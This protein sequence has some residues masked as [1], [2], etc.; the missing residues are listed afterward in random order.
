MKLAR[1]TWLVFQRQMQLVMRN[2]VWVIIGVVQPLYFLFL[3]GPLLRPALGVSTNAEAYRIFI[4]GLL[5]MLA[6]FG[7]MFVGFGLIAELRAGVIERSRVTPVSRLALMVGRSLRD[8]VTLFF[9]ALLIIGLAIPFGLKVQLGDLL[10]AFLL[11]G[12]IGLMLS[13]L[14]NAIALKLRSEDALAPLMNGV[15]QPLLLLSGILLP[16]ALAP[17]WLQRVADWNPFSWAVDAS[18]ALFAGDPSNSS[19]WQALLILG[20]LTA[21]SLV[22]AARSFARGVR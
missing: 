17:V 5:V 21:V 6:M 19:V 9:Q 15:A 14:S 12:L 10:L 20:V 11:L 7:S 4:P 3:F 22:W 16:L 8:V 18:R 1:D 2:P 13:A